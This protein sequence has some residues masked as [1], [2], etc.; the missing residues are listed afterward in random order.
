MSISTIA[1]KDTYAGNASIS[2]AYP[3][4]FKYLSSDHVTVYADGVDITNTCTFAGDG[5]TG[6][7][8]FI[9][10]AYAPTT[11]IVV[12]LDVPLDQPV[13][14]QETGSLPAKTIEVEGFD[15]LNM[16]VRR[17]WRK[18]QDVLTFNTDEANGSTGTADNLLG[19]DGSGNLAEIP[20]STFRPS[21]TEITEADLNAST[22]ASLNLADTALQSVAAN[23]I[24]D[25]TITNPVSGEILEWNGSA[26]VNTV[27]GATVT[28]SDTAPVSPN[29]G[30]L[31][32]DSTTTQMYVYYNDGSSSQWVTVAAGS[33][34]TDASS[35]AYTPWTGS[36]SDVQTE[37]SAITGATIVVGFGANAVTNGTI[38][39]TA[40]SDINTAGGGRLIIP[41]G[42]WSITP[43]HVGSASRLLTN[44]L[45]VHFETG[46]VLTSSAGSGDLIF[47]LKGQASTSSAPSDVSVIFDGHGTMDVSAGAYVIGASSSSCISVSACKALRV[48][49]IDFI[50]GDYHFTGA[51]WVTAKD[52]LVGDVAYESTNVYTCLVAHTS[53]TFAT[54]LT[55]VKWELSTV[56]VG[57]A[58]VGGDSAINPTNITHTSIDKCTFKGFR[59]AG[60]YWGGANRSTGDLTD[61]DGGHVSVDSCS[62]IHCSS[63]VVGKRAGNSGAVSNSYFEGC[64]YGVITAEVSAGQ[65]IATAK[66]STVIGCTFFRT[67][68]PIMARF[69]THL[70]AIGNRIQDFGFCEPD[71]SDLAFGKDIGGLQLEG[72]SYAMVSGNFFKQD[73]SADVSTQK[74][75]RITSK[76]DSDAVV[77]QGGRINASNNTYDVNNAEWYDEANSTVWASSLTDNV[78]FGGAI[79]RGVTG[80]IF[81]RRTLGDSD[82]QRF[83]S[84]KDGGLATMI[85]RYYESIK[86]DTSASATLV[87]SEVQYGR[88][89]K[90]TAAGTKTITLDDAPFDGFHFF[91]YITQ[92]DADFTPATGTHKVATAGV[93]GS[94]GASRTVTDLLTRY[95]VEYTGGDEWIVSQ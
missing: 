55:A 93:F 61:D 77:F 21:S 25:V 35:V 72:A 63:G 75:I 46:A 88:C 2:T 74:C 36:A 89:F 13:S 59:D 80:T 33:P 70:I 44:N 28:S 66:R 37:L 12:V 9:T 54:D 17:V 22:N 67:A 27:S 38:L 47:W 15:R 82:S 78:C 43:S 73:E 76:T 86:I 58:A 87:A 56:G 26:W 34:S 5:T 91:I 83:Y 52:Y 11:T 1:T 4:T 3:V 50:G 30:D 65:E 8:E 81:Q 16:Q 60:V 92:G 31:W 14:L 64:R 39:D 32:F 69:Q 49:D 71:V 18:L 6:T 40:I 19:F 48:S 29:E 68:L 84:N 7:G 23:D 57:L 90:M 95:R 10:A 42:N 41:S 94:A 20:N 79:G 53:G 51:D 45:H 62:F 24:T 85:A